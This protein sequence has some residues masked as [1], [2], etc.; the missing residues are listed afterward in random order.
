[1]D[2]TIELVALKEKRDGAHVPLGAARRGLSSGP[3]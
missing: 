1:V 3:D 2:E